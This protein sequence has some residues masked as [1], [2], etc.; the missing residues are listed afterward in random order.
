[1]ISAK[2]SPTNVGFPGKNPVLHI[3][4]PGE[5][6]LSGVPA[7]LIQICKSPDHP[8]P[9]DVECGGVS[10]ISGP[11]PRDHPVGLYDDLDTWIN[12][13]MIPTTHGDPSKLFPPLMEVKRRK[14]EPHS[15][16]SPNWANAPPVPATSRT[17]R[18]IVDT[19]QPI[20]G[21]ID[22]IFSRSDT[23]IDE[24]VVNATFSAEM[25]RCSTLRLTSPRSS[26]ST[27]PYTPTR[28][29][30]RPHGAHTA[31]PRIPMPISGRIWEDIEL[32]H[33]DPRLTP[34]ISVANIAQAPLHSNIGQ[35]L[36]PEVKNPSAPS[37]VDWQDMIAATSD[38][39]AEDYHSVSRENPSA[40]PNVSSFSENQSS[41]GL[42]PS[43]IS[44]SQ[45]QHQTQKNY[46]PPQ[47]AC[48]YSNLNH[49]NEPLLRDAAI[50]KYLA[51]S[52]DVPQIFPSTMTKY[53]LP[54][55]SGSL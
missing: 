36:G 48:D 43:H 11:L 15:S 53:L 26:A 55:V 28:S 46:S 21:R 32:M 16:D 1:M 24:R 49:N 33:R 2:L 13:T 29:H 23:L 45:Q 19:V 41:P 50:Q 18:Y 40:I 34:I 20:N 44:G 22:D 42:G 4:S 17:S 39:V 47:S 27:A 54:A 25:R 38:I 35:S 6:S 3:T 52:H 14:D 12:N 7:I 30:F 9:I 37:F 51:P 8:R 10:S 31:T 5:C